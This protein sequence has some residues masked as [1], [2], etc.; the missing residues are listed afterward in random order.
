MTNNRKGNSA[1]GGVFVLCLLLA[2]GSVFASLYALSGGSAA[3]CIAFCIAAMIISVIGIA[4][5]VIR[6]NEKKTICNCEC[7]KDNE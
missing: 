5:G 4:I 1:I 7:K 3:A 2:L 6:E